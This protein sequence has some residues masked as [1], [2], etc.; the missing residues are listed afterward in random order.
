MEVEVGGRLLQVEPLEPP[1][2]PE[3][4]TS[5]APYVWQLFEALVDGQQRSMQV[6]TGTGI[7]C[8]AAKLGSNFLFCMPFIGQAVSY[9]FL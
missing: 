6:I 7:L 1:S 3:G 9:W 2:A 5:R 8:T 4:A